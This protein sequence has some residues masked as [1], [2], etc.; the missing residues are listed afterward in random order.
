M[1]GRGK[2]HQ[3]EVFRQ[4]LFYEQSNFKILILQGI[5]PSWFTSKLICAPGTVDFDQL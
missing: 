5:S 3:N 1:K 4:F 2:Q